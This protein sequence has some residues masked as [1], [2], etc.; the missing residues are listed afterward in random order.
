MTD[1]EPIK[2]VDGG[3][4]VGA[5]LRYLRE[6]Q[7]LKA[8]EVAEKIGTNQSQ[9]W[10][11]DN[12]QSD[13]RSSLLFRYIRAVNGDANDVEMLINNREATQSDGITLAKLRL[14]IRTR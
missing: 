4:A 7:G 5:Y 14:G 12:W 9:V 8:T 13:T 1:Y 11:I 6:A 2:P 10:R 3:V